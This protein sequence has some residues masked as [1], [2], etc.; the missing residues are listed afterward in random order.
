MRWWT[1]LLLFVLLCGIGLHAT[2]PRQVEYVPA[3]GPSYD[4]GLDY[5]KQ[6]VEILTRM[7]KRLE[8]IEAKIGGA[9]NQEGDLAS[10]LSRR[11][12]SCHQ[13]GAAESKGGDFVLIE[14]DGKLAEL[15]V[16]EKRRIVREVKSGKMPKDATLPEAEKKLLIEFF[17]PK[18]EQKK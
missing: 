5:Q 10:V 1:L 17:S 2:P 6:T 13:D 12:L 4:A 9:A 18:E 16:A 3:Y 8:R 15:S 7:D 14:K 11:C